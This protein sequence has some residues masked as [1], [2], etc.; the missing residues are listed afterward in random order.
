MKKTST[1]TPSPDMSL[2]QIKNILARNRETPEVNNVELKKDIE[3]LARL[4][5]MEALEQARNSSKIDSEESQGSLFGAAGDKDPLAAYTGLADMPDISQGEADSILAQYSKL[6]K[7]ADRLSRASSYMKEHGL[8]YFD[9]GLTPTDLDDKVAELNEQMKALLPDSTGEVSPDTSHSIPSYDPAHE[10]KG[11]NRPTKKEDALK[12]EQMLSDPKYGINIAEN[13]AE[14]IV[15]EIDRIKGVSHRPSRQEIAEASKPAHLK[16]GTEAYNEYNNKIKEADELHNKYNEAKYRYLQNTS[17]LVE[18]L[19][20][21]EKRAIA[22]KDYKEQVEQN[23]KSR[24]EGGTNGD[25]YMNDGTHPFIITLMGNK[26][27]PE[28]VARNAA[29]RGVIND[30]TT[31][32]M[33][34]DFEN[35]PRYK[36][37]HTGPEG[38]VQNELVSY[39]DRADK[40]SNMRTSGTDSYVLTIIDE[41]KEKAKTEELTPTERKFIQ[42]YDRAYDSEVRH[43]DRILANNDIRKLRPEMQAINKEL[44]DYDKLSQSWAKSMDPGAFREGRVIKGSDPDL[45]F[46]DVSGKIGKNGKHAVYAVMRKGD[47]FQLY[48]AEAVGMPPEDT[49]RILSGKDPNY[50]TEFE[51]YKAI[52]KPKDAYD[53]IGSGF[54]VS[55]YSLDQA[56]DQ[57][58]TGV[59]QNVDQI[60]PE[61]RG[62]TYEQNKKLMANF[63]ASRCNGL[64]LGEIGRLLNL[65]KASTII[66]KI[67]APAGFKQDTKTGKWWAP[68][69]APLDANFLSAA[70]M[71]EKAV[72]VAQAKVDA[73]WEKE[74]KANAKGK[75]TIPSAKFENGKI[76]LPKDKGYYIHTSVGPTKTKTVVHPNKNNPDKL[77]KGI[78]VGTDRT[79]AN[80]ADKNV[81]KRTKEDEERQNKAMATLTPEEQERALASQRKFQKNNPGV[82]LPPRSDNVNVGDIAKIITAGPSSNLASLFGV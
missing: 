4:R 45:Q 32:S 35:V 20:A 24:A 1:I 72:E 21:Q 69:K 16:V 80:Y 64:T 38:K 5:Q 46:I 65:R 13:G 12:V 48:P 70:E 27:D 74:A 41:L 25:I 8:N 28:S 11:G 68:G 40:F 31:Q 2:N 53:A 71:D 52:W 63:D 58:K 17:N 34:A 22:D 67:L 37:K 73:F 19:A 15:D 57:I 42:A 6:K 26:L 66:H 82:K 76:L 50:P 43:R 9:N 36:N 51:Q 55:D 49:K 75:T 56:V 47:K 77:V 39:L 3:R 79:A 59:E 10:L 60:D 18:R 61:R 81:Q 44:K 23:K 30:E 14:N 62:K 7:E 54:P 78:Q 33:I 29:I